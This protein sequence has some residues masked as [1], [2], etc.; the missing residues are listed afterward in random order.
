MSDDV[1]EDMRNLLRSAR[2]PPWKVEL[3]LPRMVEAC[4]AVGML[5][6]QGHGW[7]KVTPR[8]AQEDAWQ[9]VWDLLE[10]QGVKDG[11]E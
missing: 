6:P 4:V 11:A 8:I 9:R 7:Y 1:I 10:A 2:F 5:V 3:V